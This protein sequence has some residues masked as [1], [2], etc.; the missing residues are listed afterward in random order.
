MTKNAIIVKVVLNEVP[1]VSI[2]IRQKGWSVRGSFRVDLAT[3]VGF[4]KGFT[5]FL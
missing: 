4:M 5:G 3:K 1:G 2:S